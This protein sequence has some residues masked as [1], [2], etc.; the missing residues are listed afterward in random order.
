MHSPQARVITAVGLVVLATLPIR[1][2]VHDAIA[3][4]AEVLLLFGRVEIRDSRQLQTLPVALDGVLAGGPKWTRNRT[5]LANNSSVD[6]EPG[7][8]VA[9]GVKSGP[10][11][12]TFI[13]KA[14]AEAVFDF[15]LSA[16]D[17][18][19]Q[20]AV[21]P[22]AWGI[23]A[24]IKPRVLATLVVKG[25]IPST[26]TTVAFQCTFHKAAMA[27][28]LRIAPMGRSGAREGRSSSE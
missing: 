19:A 23:D 11:G 25:N 6:I 17:F 16:R 22:N 27:G 9:F 20:P 28:T 15:G 14:M 1:P 26:I 8:S 13:D 10:H 12:I 4:D 3:A 5:L 24:T 21:G 2:F 7:Q 18:K